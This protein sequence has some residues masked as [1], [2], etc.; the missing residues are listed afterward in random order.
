MN[1]E[2]RNAI[3]R[4]RDIY[5]Y[6]TEGEPSPDEEEESQKELI[7]LLESLIMHIPPENMEENLELLKTS[8]TM[9]KDWVLRFME[10]LMLLIAVRIL[11]LIILFFFITTFII[12]A[13]SLIQIHILVYIPIWQ[14]V[15]LWMIILG[16]MFSGDLILDT[17]EPQ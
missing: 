2:F 3:K 5:N 14:S 17:M 4:M 11:H 1:D 13:R 6:L 8:L 16:V 9:A 15:T 7:T 12:K 10:W